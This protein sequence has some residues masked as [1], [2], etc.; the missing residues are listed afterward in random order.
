MRLL[1]R[2]YHK[3]GTNLIYLGQ[4]VLLDVCGYTLLC[5]YKDG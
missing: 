5:G 3:D 2:V 4:I 1:D